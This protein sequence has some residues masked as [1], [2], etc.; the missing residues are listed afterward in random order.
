MGEASPYVGSDLRRLAVDPRLRRQLVDVPAYSGLD[1][2]PDGAQR[3][4]LLT[5]AATA[6]ARQ[7]RADQAAARLVEADTAAPLRLRLDF[8]RELVAALAARTT[9]TVQVAAARNLAERAGLR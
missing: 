4:R 3:S 8:A 1:E 6:E 9:N 5:V 2:A 7:D